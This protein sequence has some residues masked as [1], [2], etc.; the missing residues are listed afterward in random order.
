MPLTGFRYGGL[1]EQ[2]IRNWEDI[3]CFCDSA[4]RVKQCKKGILRGEKEHCDMSSLSQPDITLKHY[5]RDN[6]VYAKIESLDEQRKLNN[7]LK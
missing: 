6:A 5:A 4:R 2:A 1:R 7:Y 3:P